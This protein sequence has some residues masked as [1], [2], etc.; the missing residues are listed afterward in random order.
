MATD[1]EKQTVIVTGGGTGI[2]RAVAAAFVDAGANV[3][4]FGR[5]EAPLRATAESLGPRVVWYAVDVSDAG[6]LGKALQHVVGIGGIDVLV[7]NAGAGGRTRLTTE[8]PLDEARREWDA[9]IAANLTSAFLTSIAVAPHLR[10]PG[11][12][13]V[14]VS[15]IAALTG[16]SRAAL[17]YAAAKAGI[18]G[19]TYAFARALSPQGITVN[20][21]APGLILGTEF[22]AS[23]GEDRVRDIVGQTPVGRAG[24]PED[25]VAA[26]LYLTSPEAAFVTGEIVNVNGG[27]LFGR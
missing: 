6:Q 27:W 2:G 4:I 16:G 10:R 15:S 9:V 12:R 20:A 18:H 5:R 23:Y 26:I 22:T 8:T 24:R 17:A 14:N 25:V 13:I 3:I 7:N 1:R 19:L 11:G 21:V